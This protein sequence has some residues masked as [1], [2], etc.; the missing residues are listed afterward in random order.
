[1]GGAK[2]G[3]VSS[4][5]RSRGVKEVK[6]KTKILT[7]SASRPQGGRGSDAQAQSSA[8]DLVKTIEPD[9]D[10]KTVKMWWKPENGS[11]EEDMLPFRDDSDAAELVMFVVGNNCDAEIFCELQ[12]EEGGSTFMDRIREKGKG[13]AENENNSEDESSDESVRDV[14]F[15]DSEEER[16]KGFAEEMDDVVNGNSAEHINQENGEAN[17]GAASQQVNKISITE[18]MGKQHVI[19]DEYMTDE[20]DSGAEDDSSDERTCVIRF[21]EEDKLSKDYVFKVG[22]EFRS[23]RQFKDAI[24]E[25]N[26]LNGRDVK[27]EKNDSNRCRVVCKDKKKCNYTVLCSRVLTSTTFRI[28]TLFAKHKCGRKFFNKSA[29][30]EWV[31]KVIVDGLKNNTKMKLNEVVADIRQ[32]Y[33]TEIPGCRA[34]R[35]RQIARQIVEGDSSKQF[36]MLWSYG[37]EL[38]RASAGNTFKINTT[39]FAPGLKPRFERCYI[40]FD[41]TKKA[42]TKA[43]RPFIG[44]DGCHLKHKYGGIL[45]IAVGR[46]PNDQYLPVAFA[47]VESETKDSWSWFM[48]LLIEDIGDGRWCFISDQQKGLVQVFEEEYPAYEHR[49]C[50][51]HLYANFKKKFGGGTLYRDL[52]MAAAKATYFEAHEAKML[53]I[54]E[55]KLEAYEWLETIPKNKWCKHAF[56]FFSKCDVLMNN[57]SEFFN[58]TIL[59]QRDKPIITMLEWIRNYLMGRFATLREKVDG[60]NGQIMSKPLKRLDREIEKSASWTATY[61]GRYS[62]QVTHVLFTDSFVVDLEK[63]TYSCNFWEIVGIPC[64]HAVAAIYRKVDDPVSYVNKCYHKSTYEACYN[65]VITPLNG[66]NKWPKTTQPDMFPPLYKRGAGRP[67][68]LRRREADEVNQNKWQRTNTS[69]RCKVCFELGHNKRTCKKNKQ[70]GPTSGVQANVQN[71]EV[72]PN[73]VTTTEDVPTQASQTAQANVAAKKEHKAKGKASKNAKSRTSGTTQPSNSSPVD[74][75]YEW[76]AETLEA[77]LDWDDILD[78]RPLSVDSAPIKKKDAQPTKDKEPVVAANDSGPSTATTATKARDGTKI[79]FGPAPK[80]PKNKPL[81]QHVG[82]SSVGQVPPKPPTTSSAQVQPKAKKSKSD[83]DVAKRQS[84]RLRSLKTKAIPGPGKK[85]DHPLVIVE[86]DEATEDSTSGVPKMKKWDDIYKGLTQ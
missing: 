2:G 62:F 18:E 80:K 45:F 52:M 83:M 55:A 34:F 53:M 19:E 29:K 8:R 25:H 65:E 69:H 48:K 64:R 40:S 24:L 54:K 42:L 7:K 16:M 73:N 76:D 79:F 84:D 38:R 28:K 58:A 66:Q 4:T 14:H 10:E 50:L 21:N 70:I 77:L 41:G 68:K 51:R 46:D 81:K 3:K 23:L 6:E 20:L 49:F 13:K 71:E 36:S 22:M 82:A 32:R 30:A 67:K 12:P 27:F 39:S 59:L 85:P 1:M 86:E 33:S 35:A 56:P 31:A 63:H 72:P 17:P 43:C 47:V 44:L 9:F 37:A 74:K 26:V 75:Y 15:D 11:F 60:Y 61:A 57:L 5:S 78:I